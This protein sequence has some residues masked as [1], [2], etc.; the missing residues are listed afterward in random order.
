M[1]PIEKLKDGHLREVGALARCIHSIND[2]KY[3]ELGLQRG[4]FIFLTRVVEHPGVNL[5]EL[6]AM[7]R[8]DKTTTTKAVQKLLAAG[9]VARERDAADA[10]M[11]RLVP[12]DR[13]QA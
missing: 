6:S 12:T 7:L 13:A 5:A 4:Q 9:L 10:R 2:L 11:W 8:V 1:T 3:R